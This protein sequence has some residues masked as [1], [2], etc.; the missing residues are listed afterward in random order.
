VTAAAAALAAAL[1]F[2]AGCCDGIAYV[3]WH[4]FAANMTGNTILFG[5]AV[6][7]G[8]PATALRTLAS[9]GAFTAGAALATAVKER[10]SP[11]VAF[12]AEAL[13]L[14]VAAVLHG[15]GLQLPL[16]AFAMG[17]QN[18]TFSTFAGIRA[19]TSFVTG[20]YAQFGAAF[21][22]LIRRKNVAP[23]RR[24]LAV[25]A[26]LVVAYAVGG[27]SAALLAAHSPYALIA[28]VPVVL[29][30][31]LAVARGAGRVAYPPSQT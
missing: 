26:A 30:I 16:I 27:G 9:I 11:I 12:V 3:R 4:M 10:T 24:T 25:L 14:A 6:V 5:L 8:Q 23:S 19:N 1:A 18:P 21:A 20:D 28:V 17:I 29:L 31:A 7:G 2:V 22:D 15:A 13:V